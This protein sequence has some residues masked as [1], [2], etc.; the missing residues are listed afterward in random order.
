MNNLHRPRQIG[1]FG[2]DQ[3]GQYQHKQI[4]RIYKPK[5]QIPFKYCFHDTK[6]KD[7]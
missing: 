5:Y 4:H 1:V 7:F 3:I 6:M 2:H